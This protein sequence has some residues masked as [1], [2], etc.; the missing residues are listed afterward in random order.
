MQSLVFC[1]TLN[2]FFGASSWR[3]KLDSRS[4]NV[5]ARHWRS[6]R[7][8]FYLATCW[9][10]PR[11]ICPREL[12]GSLGDGNWLRALARETERGERKKRKKDKATKEH[13]A[14]MSSA[15]VSGWFPGRN[16]AAGNDDREKNPSLQE[17]TGRRG[18]PVSAGPCLNSC[19]HHED[20]F[21][22]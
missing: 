12:E 17:N 9:N 20:C 11:E 4:S 13:S 14:P 16:T 22:I 7:G 6:G 10:G 3:L 2:G 5:H 1:L 21:K 8:E 15:S 18:G 19:R